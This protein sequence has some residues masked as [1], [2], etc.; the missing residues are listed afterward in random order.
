MCLIVPRV[1]RTQQLERCGQPCYEFLAHSDGAR[2]SLFGPRSNLEPSCIAHQHRSGRDHGG[3]SC[4]VTE[5]TQRPAYIQRWRVTTSCHRSLG[6][7]QSLQQR[8]QKQCCHIS[9]TISQAHRRRQHRTLHR[10]QSRTSY[11]QIALSER[12]RAV[13]PTAR[14][15]LRPPA[16]RGHAV[17]GFGD[18]ALRSTR[19]HSLLG[20]WVS[21]VFRV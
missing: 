10:R 6:V 20:P 4:F 17:T 5:A 11:A 12:G 15:P 7:A 16:A 14:G 13:Q 1:R 8:A 3:G 21:H 9:A 18:C 2:L 19:S